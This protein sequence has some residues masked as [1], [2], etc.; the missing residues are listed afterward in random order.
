MAK[1]NIR[2]PKL[3]RGWRIVRNLAVALVCLYALWVRAGYPLPTPELEFRRLER[4]NLLGRA[5]IQGILKENNINRIVF[6]TQGDQVLIGYHNGRT[7]ES[8]PKEKSGP[9]LFL[10]SEYNTS[11]T[12][13]KE[14]LFAAADLPDGTA[15]ARLEMTVDC[16][17]ATNHDGGMSISAVE[18]GYPRDDSLNWKQWARDYQTEGELLK[19]GGVLFRVPRGDAEGTVSIEQTLFWMLTRQNTFLYQTSAVRGV[20]C[21]MDAVFY[22]AD[23]RELGRAA[24][25]TPEDGDS[26]DS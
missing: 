20:N 23:G 19:D 16:W 17:F 7:L 2:L 14:L 22:G 26:V 15:S 1:R 9:T 18:G 4:E 13:T 25:A 10:A 8:W 24:L 5:E 11:Y 3:S 21:H 12:N 6:G